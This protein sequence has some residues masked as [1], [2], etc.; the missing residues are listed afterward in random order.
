[1]AVCALAAARYTQKAHC[2][3]RVYAGSVYYYEIHF[4]L[5]MVVV[6]DAESA[7]KCAEWH[8][9]PTHRDRQPPLA[10]SREQRR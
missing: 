5:S 1:M 6:V 4:S 9:N 10:S 7:E 8:E 3:A 2:G